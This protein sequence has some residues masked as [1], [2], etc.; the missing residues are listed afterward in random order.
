[1]LQEA[2]FRCSMTMRL[3]P[4]IRDDGAQPNQ[5]GIYSYFNHVISATRHPGWQSIG[6]PSSA[7][8]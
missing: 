4:P 7:A 3:S 5:A 6:A 2:H 8:L 1:L